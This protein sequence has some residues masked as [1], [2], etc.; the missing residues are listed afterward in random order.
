MIKAA[1]ATAVTTAAAPPAR[2]KGRRNF[3]ASFGAVV[4]EVPEEKL[5]TDFGSGALNQPRPG[6]LL[7][8]AVGRPSPGMRLR[9]V[10]PRHMARVP[11]WC[12]V[13]AS[14]A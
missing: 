4:V 3:G 11:S 10:S 13:Q 12:N 6:R 5:T 1:A 7:I 14:A 9:Q 8:V 2:N